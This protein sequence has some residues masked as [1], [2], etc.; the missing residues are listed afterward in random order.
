VGNR[1]ELILVNDGSRDATWNVICSLADSDARVVGVNLSRNHGHQTALSAGLSLVRGDRVLILDADL[2]DPP[3]LLQEMMQLM[4]AGA[5]VVYGQR[6]TREG[7]TIFKQASASLFYR[8]LSHLAEVPI[9][10]DTGDFRLMSRR[11]VDV[12]NQMPERHRFIRG[13]VSWIGFRQVALPYARQ[14]RIAGKS[15]YPFRRMLR[16]AFD[17]IT[18]FSTRPLRIASLLGLTFALA[19]AVGI[20][21]ALI[22]WVR[23]VTIPGW[24]SVMIVLLALGGLQLSVLGIM[25]EYLGR[26]YIESKQRPLYIIQDI[27]RSNS[28]PLE[29]R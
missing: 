24:T 20:V 2:Q 13:M 26:L 10:T 11:A 15:S 28:N 7:E 12:L 18:G 16:L 6:V 4:D 1:F 5:D 9:P 25:G 19:G 22:A 27:R 23:G 8:L 14:P 3:E 17:A 21:V 29:A